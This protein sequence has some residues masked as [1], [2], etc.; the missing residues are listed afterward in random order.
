MEKGRLRDFFTKEYMDDLCK[1]FHDDE[2]D[3]YGN[4]SNKVLKWMTDIV[5][6]YEQFGL[7]AYCTLESKEF[8]ESRMKNALK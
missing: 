2:L 8:I 3:I 6:K 4:R 7:S 1:K 5:E